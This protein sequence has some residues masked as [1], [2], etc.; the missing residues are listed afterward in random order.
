MILTSTLKAVDYQVD[1]RGVLHPRITI[2]EIEGKEFKVRHGVITMHQLWDMVAS[3]IGI[4]STVTLETHDTFI[5]RRSKVISIGKSPSE[6]LQIPSICPSCGE[7]LLVA[8]TSTFARLQCVNPACPSMLACSLKRFFD[9]YQIKGYGNI[10]LEA[11]MRHLTVEQAIITVGS[12]SVRARVLCGTLFTL[13]N[14]LGLADRSRLRCEVK[15]FDLIMDVDMSSKCH[16]VI[17]PIVT[18][19]KA[20][21][22]NDLIEYVMTMLSNRLA[23]RERKEDL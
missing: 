5:S 3:G 9:V 17:I 6:R 22:R 11:L 2:D 10:K 12:R 1:R 20:N 15:R 13:L 21:C 16:Q 4:G 14:A 8:Y 7:R 23:R 19:L 18:F